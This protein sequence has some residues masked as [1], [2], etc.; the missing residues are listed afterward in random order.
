MKRAKY[1]TS[2]VAN[3]LLFLFRYR[4]D[5]YDS[6]KNRDYTSEDDIEL[7]K[8]IKRKCKLDWTILLTNFRYQQYVWR[9][10]PNL[11]ENPKLET[12]SNQLEIACRNNSVPNNIIFIVGL[13]NAVTCF[14]GHLRYYF[15]IL[16]WNQ[17]L[18]MYYNR[19]YRYLANEK[20]FGKKTILKKKHSHKLHFVACI[21]HR[22]LTGVRLEKN[23]LRY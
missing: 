17:R 7:L 3:I 20:K 23:H 4:Y 12:I 16:H 5:H 10:Y 1:L 14:N 2:T 18:F 19:Y 8:Y 6:R 21:Y 11:K 15:Y 13:V 22:Q 9:F